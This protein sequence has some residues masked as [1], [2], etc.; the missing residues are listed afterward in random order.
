MGSST[1]WD[2]LGIPCLVVFQG[3]KHYVRKQLLTWRDDFN[4]QPSKALPFLTEFHLF[5]TPTPVTLPSVSAIKQWDAWKKFFLLPPII[6]P[7]HLHCYVT[8]PLTLAWQSSNF[9]IEVSCH[10]SLDS[11]D[12]FT[13]QVC[14]HVTGQGCRTFTFTV[15]VFIHPSDISGTHRAVCTLPVC[16]SAWWSKHAFNS[17][18]S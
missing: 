6:L 13:Q 16:L 14:I 5:L 4:T 11:S 18:S 2:L 17:G 10:F 12:T 1:G 8:R 9:C 7:C 15:S 3:L